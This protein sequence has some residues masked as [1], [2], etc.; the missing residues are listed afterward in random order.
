M[1][2]HEIGDIVRHGTVVGGDA[3]AFVAD[4]GQD[5][6]EM[7]GQFKELVSPCKYNTIYGS[8]WWQ[9]AGC[10]CGGAFDIHGS[11][12]QAKAAA[13][14]NMQ[15]RLCQVSAVD[16]GI[17]VGVY[18]QHIALGIPDIP[19]GQGVGGMDDRLADPVAAGICPEFAGRSKNISPSTQ[20]VGKRR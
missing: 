19:R 13:S 18:T 11:T 17:A 14:V 1:C 2:T 6:A 4:R 3:V 12:Q 16:R 15:F 8:E 5:I 20:A 10:N 9:W 7:V